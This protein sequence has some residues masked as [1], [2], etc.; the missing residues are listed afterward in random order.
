[1]L[2]FNDHSNPD[3]SFFTAQTEVGGE[4]N[5]KQNLKVCSLFM[6]ASLGAK[7][8]LYSRS[9]FSNFFKQLEKC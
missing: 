3:D 7:T 4:R 6:F 8:L 1:M 9:L 5:L 2:T